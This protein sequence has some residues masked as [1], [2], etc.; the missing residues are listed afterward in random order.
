MKS[1]LYENLVREVY[2]MFVRTSAF[3]RN[4]RFVIGFENFGILRLAQFFQEYLSRFKI[5]NR[6][7]R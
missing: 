5:Q 6:I 7:L 1:S 4:E 3:L 2:G